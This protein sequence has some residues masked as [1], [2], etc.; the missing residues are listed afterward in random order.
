MTNYKRQKGYLNLGA[1]DI[2]EAKNKHGMQIYMTRV[3]NKL[4]QFLLKHL[5]GIF[6]VDDPR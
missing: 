5:L 1:S 3:P 4:R 6:W 2:E